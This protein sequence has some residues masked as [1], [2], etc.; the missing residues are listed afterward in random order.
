MRN[1]LPSSASNAFDS[2]FHPTGTSVT[3]LG[4][5]GITTV[6]G[7]LDPQWECLL[8]EIPLP[9]NTPSSGFLENN[10][11]LCNQNTLTDS[12]HTLTLKVKTQG[13]TFWFDSFQYTPS[14]NA[15]LSDAIVRIENNDPVIKYNGFSDFAG[16]TNSTNTPGGTMQ[17]DF[18]GASLSYTHTINLIRISLYRQIIDLG[19]LCSQRTSPN[20]HHI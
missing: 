15:D 12:K 4:S 13:A 1:P 10:W 6:N 11:V 19:R 17:V 18:I 16:F 20:S 14:P 2:P 7:V 9:V 8:D 3:L 5:I